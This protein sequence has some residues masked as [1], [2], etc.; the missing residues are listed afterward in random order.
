MERNGYIDFVKGIAILLV[1]AGHSIQYCY[2][3]EFF[4]QGEF[5]GNPLF[6]F[7][8]SFHMPLF[9]AVSGYLL[10]RSLTHRTE[11]EV[12]LRRLRQLGVPILSFGILAFLIKWMVSPIYNVGECAKMLFYTCISNLWFLWALLYNLLLLLLI[13]RMDD[14]IWI[15]IVVGMTL[16]FIPDCNYLPARYT[17]LYPFLVVGYSKGKNPSNRI[18]KT[19][20]KVAVIVSMGLLYILGLYANRTLFSDIWNCNMVGNVLHIMMRQLIALFALG[21]II[22]LLHELYQNFTKNRIVLVIMYA[23]RNSLV[24]YYFQT[25][26]F[27]LVSRI[28]HLLPS[29][30]MRGAFIGY[31][32]ITAECL[33]LAK[34]CVR[35]KISFY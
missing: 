8:Y 9:M 35:H 19:R 33:L 14:N 4:L 1:L 27:I 12:A 16:Y 29:L 26:V 18:H 3:A 7:I 31:V 10:A 20:G 23:G 5:Y 21:W 22:P 30:G 25:L 34:W 28:C 24:I 32:V 17:F 11:G 2:G 6:R 13:R 15:Y